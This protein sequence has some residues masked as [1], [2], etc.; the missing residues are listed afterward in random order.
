MKGPPDQLGQS[1]TSWIALTEN[2]TMPCAHFPA[3]A[4][5]IELAQLRGVKVAREVYL[6][7]A[8]LN[9]QSNRLEVDGLTYQI[10]LVNDWDGFTVAGV[11][12]V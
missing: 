9:P 2:D 10:T 5:V 7:R 1:T 8:G 12:S 6:E 3:G 11:V 4:K